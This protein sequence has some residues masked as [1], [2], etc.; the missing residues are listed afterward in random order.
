MEISQAVYVLCH[1]L[2]VSVV[3]FACGRVYPHRSK[4][5]EQSDNTAWG[6][7]LAAA[8]LMVI[9]GFSYT[10]YV[11]L[12]ML[13][14]PPEPEAIANTFLTFAIILSAS[15]VSVWSV[16]EFLQ[17]KANKRDWLPYVLVPE[18]GTFILHL[19]VSTP[20]TL[21][22]YFAS[23]I[24]VMFFGIWYFYRRYCIYKR[25]LLEEYSN[26]TD[27][28]LRWVWGLCVAMA[29]QSTNFIAICVVDWPWLEYAGLAIVCFSSILLQKCVF[30]TRALSIYLI[31]QAAVADHIMLEN[32]RTPD[33][34]QS[35][36]IDEIA[37][38]TP[39]EP[40]VQ[41]ETMKQPAAEDAEKAAETV[42]TT[43]IAEAQSAGEQ[44]GAA[45]QDAVA[46]QNVAAEQDT[47]DE[48]DSA[49]QE[50]TDDP[51]RKVNNVIRLKLKAV[52]EDE[53]LFL[54]PD[55]TREML[56]SAIKVN[57]TYLSEYLRNEGL[58]YYNYINGLR[59]RYAVKLLRSHPDLPLL[60]VSFRSGF[61]NPAT[62]RR[63]FRDIMG[64]LP[65]EYEVE[66][67]Q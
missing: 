34:I 56:C 15:I 16:N 50:A 4:K 23:V 63:A 51:R 19:V 49:E 58:T 52:C 60:D 33:A 5:I 7:R 22:I 21:A 66:P 65:S 46:E 43:E 24:F 27:R 30:G 18:V 8:H 36:G 6:V 38:E 57:R 2:T 14:L 17:L 61:S 20:T 45:G 40:V 67:A 25:L 59:I 31:E 26:L 29:I 42:E 62:F 41:P 37:N 44:K 1:L 39:A 55:L 28:E 12:F 48:Q 9:W 32:E 64:C 11:P 10:F 54:D 13:E 3:A 35:E 47:A 53:C